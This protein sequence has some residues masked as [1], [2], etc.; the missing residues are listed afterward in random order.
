MHTSGRN[1]AHNDL[2]DVPKS[3]GAESCA[4]RS[5]ISRPKT[6]APPHEA[7]LQIVID[8][9][10]QLTSPVRERIPAMVRAT[11]EADVK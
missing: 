7:E 4:N 1:G 9:W 10:P 3:G 11:K 6:L 8:A 5:L 2:A